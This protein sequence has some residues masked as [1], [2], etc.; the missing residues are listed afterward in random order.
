[1]LQGKL[2]FFSQGRDT[3]SVSY[4]SNIFLPNQPP[5]RTSDYGFDVGSGWKTNVF[6]GS[7]LVSYELRENLFLEL[8]G[9]YRKQDTKT[10]PITSGNT[11]MVSFGV[12][13]N[14][15]RREFDF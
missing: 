1:L 3:G 5:Y 7:M 13:W 4:G 15:Q 11:T 12:R 14:M 2:I 9:V 6:Y 10:T 8:F